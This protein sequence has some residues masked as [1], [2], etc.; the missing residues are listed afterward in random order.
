MEVCEHLHTYNAMVEVYRLWQPEA[1]IQQ[2]T[3]IIET[4]LSSGMFTS[5]ELKEIN[6]CHIYLQA[7]FISDIMNLEGNKIEEW[8]GCG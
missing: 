6:Y 4:L 1:N 5:K 2:D 8:A 7:F 3:V